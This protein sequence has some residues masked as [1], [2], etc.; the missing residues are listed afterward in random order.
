MIDRT[1]KRLV[2][3]WIYG[4]STSDGPE[5]TASRGMALRLSNGNTLVNYGTGGVIREVTTDKKTVFYVKFDL[6]SSNDY[7]NKLVG[8][9]FFI[10]DLYSLNG[11]GPK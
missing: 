1:N 6:T 7:F 3:T 10:D 9:N 11:G 5:W 4:D 8:H 2:R